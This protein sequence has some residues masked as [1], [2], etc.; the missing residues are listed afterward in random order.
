M[1]AIEM[2]KTAVTT[3]REPSPLAIFFVK[4]TATTCAALV[5]F[6]VVFTFVTG[7]IEEKAEEL[8]ILKGGPAFWVTMENKLYKLASAPDLPPEK[9]EKI[10]NALQ[11]LSL[12]YKPYVDAIA[13]ES[14]S[15]PQ[16]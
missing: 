15:Q 7:F 11:T 16:R 5:F 6:Y 10:V 3:A 1:S 9:K 8:A 14:K 13:G 2:D 4:L 12:R